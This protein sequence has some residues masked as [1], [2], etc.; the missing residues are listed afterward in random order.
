MVVDVLADTVTPMPAPSKFALVSLPRLVEHVLSEKSSTLTVSAELDPMIFGVVSELLGEL[1][2]VDTKLGAVGPVSSCVYDV[3]RV[4]FEALLL[5][6]MAC[7]YI[8]V[9]AFE[10]TVAVI[11]APSKVALVPVPTCVLH[12][13]LL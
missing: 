3:S 10:P 2:F 7:A 4:Q 1:G 8:A 6:S 9:V 5:L 11:P 13:A 12:A